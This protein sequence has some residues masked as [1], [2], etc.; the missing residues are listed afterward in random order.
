MEV[1]SLKN[2]RFVQIAGKRYRFFK[3][4]DRIEICDVNLTNKR[5]IALLA[6]LI[7]I[8]CL[9]LF[10]NYARTLYFEHKMSEEYVV[11]TVKGWL[12]EIQEERGDGGNFNLITDFDR[13]HLTFNAIMSY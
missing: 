11:E 13:K 2:S 3:R 6:S 7:L 4:L 1:Q 10:Y 8:Y 12:E 5:K 9:Y